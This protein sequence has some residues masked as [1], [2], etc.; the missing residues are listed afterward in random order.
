[1]TLRQAKYRSGHVVTLYEVKRKEDQIGVPTWLV[2]YSSSTHPVSKWAPLRFSQHRKA[3][4]YDGR[5]K[6]YLSNF[7]VAV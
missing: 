3:Y 5:Q 1:M 4:F 2:R 7:E 6:V